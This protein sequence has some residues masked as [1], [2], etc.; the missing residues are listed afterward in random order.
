MYFLVISGVAL[1]G[2]I[3]A[4]FWLKDHLRSPVLARIAYSEPVARLALAGA[5]FAVLGV[6]LIVGD[7]ISR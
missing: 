6:L 2:S 3:L 7:A 5:A 4:L 1:V